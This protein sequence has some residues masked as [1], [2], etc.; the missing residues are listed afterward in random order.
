MYQLI[1]KNLKTNQELYRNY[2]K[3]F[4]EDNGLVG[5]AVNEMIATMDEPYPESWDKFEPTSQE[6]AETKDPMQDL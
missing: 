4:F 6:E 3:E 1:I 5:E 2:D